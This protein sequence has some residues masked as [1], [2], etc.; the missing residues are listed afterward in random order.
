VT[1][2]SGALGGGKIR[3]GIVVSDRM[4]KTIV[5]AVESNVRHRLYKKTIR[6]QKKYMAHDEREEAKLGDVVR[7]GEFRPTSKRKRW[8]LIQVLT[9][10]ELPDIAPEAIDSTLV[11]ELAAPVVSEEAVS[12]AVSAEET[13]A[14]EATVVQE[15]APPEALEQAPAVE[16]AAAI[17]PEIPPME[18]EEPVQEDAGPEATE[19]G[20]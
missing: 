12:G 3:D 18:P 15:S 11:E 6:R 4:E 9:R 2:N 7:I 13:Q 19:E 14:E 8:S 17:E 10:A 1:A 5:V 20:R 16:E